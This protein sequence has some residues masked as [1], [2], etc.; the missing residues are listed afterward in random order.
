MCQAHSCEVTLRRECAF[1]VP[2]VD[3]GGTNYPAGGGIYRAPTL[4]YAAF[5]VEKARCKGF[6]GAGSAQVARGLQ[7][8]GADLGEFPTV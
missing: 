8:E 4:P 7:R 1:Y 3:G 6:D 5:Q 2:E